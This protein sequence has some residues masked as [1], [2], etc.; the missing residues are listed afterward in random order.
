MPSSWLRG[1]APS[2]AA[3]STAHVTSTGP[4]DILAATWRAW[5]LNIGSGVYVSPTS[6][7]HGIPRPR[8]PWPPSTQL[9]TEGNCAHPSRPAALPMSHPQTPADILPVTWRA[10]ALNMGRGVYVSPTSSSGAQ[11][12]TPQSMIKIIYITYTYYYTLGSTQKICC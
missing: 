7:M 1:I 10:W 9:V 3:S 12:H 11:H 5:A 6:S 4:A 2:L 8:A